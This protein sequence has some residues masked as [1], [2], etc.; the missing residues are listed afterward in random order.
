M[1]DVHPPHAAAHS[2][3]DIFIHL[4]TI[5][6]GLFIALSLEAGVEWL[7]NRNL[8]AEA[9]ENIRGEIEVNQKL[10]KDDVGYVQE[11]EKRMQANMNVLR[12][13]RSDPMTRGVSVQLTFNWSSPANAA[14]LSA[15]DTGALSHMPYRQVQTYADVYKQ[16]DFLTE[17]AV[18]LFRNQTQALV[19]LLIEKPPAP[20]TP[21]QL[22]EALHRCAETY[23]RLKTMEDLINGLKQNYNEALK[24]S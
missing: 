7:H 20:F 4:A 16:Q 19:P 14:W 24:N 23:L 10:I 1:L 9:R 21:A 5:T 15:R 6:I 12:T 3:R 2:W 17:T 22:D 8:V 13:L 18:D 11:D